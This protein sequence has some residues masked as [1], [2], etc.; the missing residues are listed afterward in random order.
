MQLQVS[1]FHHREP[2]NNTGASRARRTS[3][4]LLVSFS[5]LRLLPDWFSLTESS[6]ARCHDVTSGGRGCAQRRVVTRRR[7]PLGLVDPGCTSQRSTL[8]ERAE[9]LEPQP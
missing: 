5:I 1:H 6:S 9:D 3:S 7:F 4:V 8:P 2:I